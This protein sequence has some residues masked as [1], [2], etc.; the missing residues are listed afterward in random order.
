MAEC[1]TCQQ[2][3]RWAKTEGG[4]PIPLD[5]EPG[6]HGNII[7]ED[8]GGEDVAVVVR[9]PDPA[10]DTLAGV[11]FVPHHATCPQADQWRRR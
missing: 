5:P 11:K 3:I 6:L 2:P 9:P 7:I 4:R 1:R 8:Q 10:G